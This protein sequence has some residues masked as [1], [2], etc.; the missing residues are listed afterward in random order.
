MAKQ[1]TTTSSDEVAQQLN[2]L[3]IAIDVVQ[4]NEPDELASLAV[5]ELN[6]SSVSVA[7]AGF[8]LLNLRSIA[9]HGGFETALKSH[10]INR[11]RASEAMK[12]AQALM[13]LPPAVSKK[14]VHLPKAKTIEL[15]KIDPDDLERM[16]ESGELDELATLSRDDMR[17]Q[18]KKLHADNANLTAHI[19]KKDHDLKQA[20]EARVSGHYP[21][22]DFV[23]TA[24]HESFAQCEQ[25]RLCLDDL[26]QLFGDHMRLNSSPT[27]D[28][29]WLDYWNRGAAA[30]YHNAKAVAAQA[31]SL[32][33]IMESQLPEEI[34]GQIIAE[35]MYSDDDVRR[36]VD[37]RELIIQRHE[38]QKVLRNDD[39]KN[40]SGRG[41]GRPRNK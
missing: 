25:A 17:K 22:P 8:Y 9:G 15:S 13:A 32:M 1:L 10:G 34:T 31:E 18:I 4:T 38:H 40:A 14:L 33:R 5:T 3:G 30:I 16:E 7:R 24:R 36:I 27:N 29:Q 6:K 23:A 41:R 26:S 37:D 39:R 35:Y 28:M 2:M 21:Y 19:K 12:V 20:R 11:Q